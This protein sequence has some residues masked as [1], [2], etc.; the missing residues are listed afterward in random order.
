MKKITYF[1]LFSL[2][3]ILT[4]TSCEKQQEIYNQ[5]MLE[6][7]FY[8]VGK[9]VGSDSASITNLMNPSSIINAAD[10]S[11][12]REGFYSMF[13]YMTA[14]SEGFSVF[15]QEGPELFSWGGTLALVEGET[16]VWNASLSKGA[17]NMTVAEDGFYFLAIDIDLLQ[18]YLFKINNWYPEGTALV[19]NEDLLPLVNSS[20]DSINWEVF[21]IDIQQGK[22][23][24]RFYP[25]DYFSISG[26]SIKIMTYIGGSFTGYTYGG[27]Y[28]EAV[29][30]EPGVYD[31]SIKYDKVNGFTGKTD[32]P[33][34]DPRVHDYSLIGDAFYVDNDPNN[35]P[36]AWNVDFDL[37]FDPTS[38]T[39]NGIYEFKIDGMNFRANREFKIR[40]DQIWENGEMGY[41]Q[42]NYITGDAGNIVNAGGQ[43]GNF[44]T[45]AAA[46]YDV[47]FIYN[48]KTNKK[49]V[50]FKKTTK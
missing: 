33:P 15:Q 8:L 16:S 29:L 14:A 17:S 39:L 4:F 36:T 31:F 27:D 49:T 47:T 18:V 30:E 44:K 20:V 19:N 23:R 21:D 28:A 38:D 35:P 48:V 32:L 50:D 2:F 13:V 43:Y 7:G 10:E 3:A 26:D 41:P 12:A 24:M 11:V 37:V 34:Y 1:L 45:I 46:V 25:E 40:L 6:E 22:L 5:P 42:V 9:A